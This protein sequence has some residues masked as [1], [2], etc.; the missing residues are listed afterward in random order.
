MTLQLNESSLIEHEFVPE[1]QEEES[2]KAVF[3][4]SPPDER[5]KTKLSLMAARKSDEGDSVDIVLNACLV[6][7]KNIV[8]SK[9]EEAEFSKDKFRFIPNDTRL[10][11]FNEAMR[12]SRLDDE[13]KKI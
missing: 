9:G 5:L 7:W 10:D 3:I 6:G 2:E 13:Q 8:D 4:I 11:I 12:L 1:G